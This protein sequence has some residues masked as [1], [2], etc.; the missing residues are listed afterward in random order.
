MRIRVF[1]MFLLPLLFLLLTIRT[2]LRFI[3]RRKRVHNAD[4]AAEGTVT[5]VRSSKVQKDCYQF[6][7]AVRYEVD[8]Q[9]YQTKFKPFAQ[10]TPDCSVREGDTVTV[11]YQAGYPAEGFVQREAYVT[12]ITGIICSV[13]PLFFSV[14]LI[15]S[16]IHWDI[17]WFT[18]PERRL[19]GAIRLILLA[20]M[21][22][23]LIAVTTW[24]LLKSRRSEPYEGTIREIKQFGRQ[25]VLCTEYEINS[26]KQIMPI[27]KEASDK[28]NYAVGDSIRFR[29]AGGLLIG[30]E[31][32][33]NKSK[34][35]AYGLLPVIGSVFLLLM[36]LEELH[37]L[38]QM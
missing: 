10:N 3:R 16:F 7:A 34:R 14:M 20:L 5:K 17:G 36:L 31:Q 35:I 27:P 37:R 12:D 26:E 29:M 28:R 38:Q 6:T 1:L 2:I 33:K 19:I 9:T 15:D 11:H 23:G 32:E 8:G 25:T 4:A 13:L 30:I 18:L 22:L 24:A 21:F